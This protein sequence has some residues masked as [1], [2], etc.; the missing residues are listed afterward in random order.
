[1]YAPLTPLLG[2]ILNSSVLDSNQDCITEGQVQRHEA[3]SVWS[4]SVIGRW[5]SAEIQ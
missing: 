3:R 1:M 2:A 4:T 5:Q